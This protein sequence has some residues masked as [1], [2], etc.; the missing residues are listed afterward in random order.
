MNTFEPHLLNM[1][2]FVCH[3]CKEKGFSFKFFKGDLEWGGGVG[4]N[5]GP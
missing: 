1:T 4:C 3:L 2:L 5:S